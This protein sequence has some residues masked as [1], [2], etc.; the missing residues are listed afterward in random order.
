MMDQDND[1]ALG[2]DK[3]DMRAR[4]WILNV[5]TGETRALPKANWEMKELAWL[6]GGDRVVVKGTEHPE[7]DQ[8]TDRIFSVQV[9]DGT[10]KELVKP[11]GPFGEMRVTRDGTTISYV[12][13]RE[14]GPAPHDLMLLPV[15]SHA[16]RNLTG[17][18]L[19]RLVQDYHWRKDG[20][21][22][23]LAANGFSNLLMTYS[24]DG[25]RH[26]L[27]AAPGPAGNIAVRGGGGIAFVSHGA[28]R[29]PEG[30][31]LGPEDAANLVYALYDC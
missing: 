15:A 25:A 18:S 6:P 9:V 5:A 28:A 4:L 11:L 30:G 22:V 10:M 29:A 14:D 1:D 27:S 26:D 31:V 24:A 19:D 3:V 21:V 7:S 17:A 12:G 2:V 20:S 23:L 8:Y 13:P 16:A